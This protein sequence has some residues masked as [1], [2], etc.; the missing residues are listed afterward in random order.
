MQGMVDFCERAVNP[1]EAVR[2][3]WSSLRSVVRTWGVD[4]RE[5]ISGAQY[6]GLEQSRNCFHIQV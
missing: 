2:S 6:F 1:G 3:G 5:S 4:S